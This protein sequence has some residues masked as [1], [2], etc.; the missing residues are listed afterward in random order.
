MNFVQALKQ[1][2]TSNLIALKFQFFFAHT[3]RTVMKNK[4]TSISSKSKWNFRKKLKWKKIHW[5]N[6]Q[7]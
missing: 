2:V 7:Y 5:L 4:R 3:H 6:W 1:I